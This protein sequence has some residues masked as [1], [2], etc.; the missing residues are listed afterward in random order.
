MLIN[1]VMAFFSKAKPKQKAHL[2]RDFIK[3]IAP[4]VGVHDLSG[5]RSITI[6]AKH[7]DVAWMEI[8]RI[9]KT[10]D[11]PK[12]DVEPC[13]EPKTYTVTVTRIKK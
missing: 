2:G 13:S 12:Y 5:I 8:D 11:I 9:I 1:K 10:G 3:M 7:D 6:H 4:I